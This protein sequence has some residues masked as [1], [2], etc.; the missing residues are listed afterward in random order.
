MWEGMDRPLPELEAWPIYSA[1]PIP[2]FEDSQVP[3]ELSEADMDRVVAEYVQATQR[4][5]SAGFD[6]LELHCAHG[7]LLA[8]FLSPLTNLRSDQYGGEIESRARFPLRVFKAIREVWPAEKPISVRLSATDWEVDGLDGEDFIQ[9]AQLFK[10]AGCDLL[11][12]ST[13]QTTPGA[14]PEYGRLFQTPF[15]ERAR[16]EARIPTI[17]SGGISSYGDVNSI[18]A[19]GRADLC[20]VGRAQLFDP[21]WVRHSAFEQGVELPWPVQYDVVGGAYQPRMEWSGQGRVKG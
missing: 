13:G 7:Y 8:S 1:S 20:F 3:A 5:E 15:A 9:L 18:L 2:Y 6:M 11:N 21:Y 19:A 16:L 12:T 4:A 17:V 14:R 10:S